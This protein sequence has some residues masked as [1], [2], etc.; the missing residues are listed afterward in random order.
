MNTRYIKTISTS[1][2]FAQPERY[3][4]RFLS[5]SLACYVL[6][7]PVYVLVP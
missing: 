6:V 7:M 1:I 5:L 4:N 2:G 3:K